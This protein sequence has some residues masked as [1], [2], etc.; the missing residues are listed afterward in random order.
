MLPTMG[1]GF[2]LVLISLLYFAGSVATQGN[3]EQYYF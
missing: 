1:G 3:Y 2:N